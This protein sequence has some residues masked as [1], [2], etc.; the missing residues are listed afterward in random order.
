MAYIE[1]G[2]GVWARYLFVKAVPEGVCDKCSLKYQ[3]VGGVICFA[4]ARMLCGRVENPL[5]KREWEQ[6]LSQHADC[7]PVTEAR[8]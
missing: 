7:Q 2:I 1:G 3:Y 4:V 8:S 6:V 5:R